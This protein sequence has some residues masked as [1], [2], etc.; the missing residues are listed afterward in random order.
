MSTVSK[1][2]ICSEDKREYARNPSSK[3]FLFTIESLFYSQ[4]SIMISIL[5]LERQFLWGKQKID[6]RNKR[7]KHKTPSTPQPTTPFL[8]FHITKDSPIT[9]PIYCY[10]L[11]LQCSLWWNNHNIKLKVRKD[12]GPYWLIPTAFFS[13]VKWRDAS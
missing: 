5:V 10:D 9:D 11:I 8:N 6:A 3:G 13:R 12:C 7:R 4:Y 1:Q 2:F